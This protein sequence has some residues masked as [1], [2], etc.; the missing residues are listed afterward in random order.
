MT[1]ESLELA[2]VAFTLGIGVGAGVSG[3]FVFG[4]KVV[5]NDGAGVTMLGTEVD[6]GCAVG[7]GEATGEVVEDCWG[8]TVVDGTTE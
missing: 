5:E 4:T 3:E 7:A 2:R 6:V 1:V 8:A